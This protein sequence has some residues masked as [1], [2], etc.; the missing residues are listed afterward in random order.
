MSLDDKW[1]PLRPHKRDNR[2][3]VIWTVIII[4][5]VAILTAALLL[6]QTDRIAALELRVSAVET[7][8]QVEATTSRLSRLTGAAK[9]SECDKAVTNYAADDKQ[10]PVGISKVCAIPSA[11]A[12]KE[13]TSQ[14]AQ[15]RADD[16]TGKFLLTLGGATPKVKRSACEMIIQ[17]YQQENL[18]M[19]QAVNA[20]C[21]Y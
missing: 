18:R 14:T 2:N 11:E 15:E 13:A 12:D 19:P 1:P 10:V 7:Q 21:D 5:G 8:L 20:E 17:L 4:G 9:R 16:F 6:L 3:R